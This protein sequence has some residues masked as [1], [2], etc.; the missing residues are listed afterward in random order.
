MSPVHINTPLSL[1]ISFGTRTFINACFAFI[2]ETT[3]NDVCNEIQT[4]KG[5]EMQIMVSIEFRPSSSQLNP[6]NALPSRVCV[7]KRLVM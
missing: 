6:K 5:T 7:L 2:L 3:L 4:I 1:K